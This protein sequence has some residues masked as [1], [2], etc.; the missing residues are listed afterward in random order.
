MNN[1]TSLLA[2]AAL[3]AALSVPALAGTP[4]SPATVSELAPGGTLRVAVAVGPSSSA[5]RAV[6]DPA[7]G[8][9]RG[10][11]VD[12]AMSLSERLG[13]PLQLVPFESTA[14]IGNTAA[15]GAW[16]VTFLPA[17]VERAKRLD[18]STPYYLY[19]ST[20]LVRPGSAI[21]SSVAIDRPGVRVG[22]IANTTTMHNATRLLKKASVVPF[23]T[24]AELADALRAG[25]VDAAAGTREALAAVAA[26]LPGARVLEGYFHAS[27]VAAAV[28][29][30]RQ[31]GLEYLSE[32]IE[33]EKASGALLQSIE[34]AGVR[35][36]VI[37]PRVSGR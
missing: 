25:K 31:A 21:H 6:R 27:G 7:T 37:A 24:G 11:A 1:A 9:L 23:R 32:F 28:P 33:E 8:M 10:V 17:D 5:F 14:A 19:E 2:A 30:D 3:A 4:P 29:K 13:V 20:Y 36:G 35:S 16:D 26:K 22:A 12:L 34:A 18:F 15:A